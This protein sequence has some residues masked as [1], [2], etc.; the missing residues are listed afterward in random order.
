[1]RSYP[2]K[3]AMSFLFA[4]SQPRCRI[5]LWLVVVLALYN[6]VYQGCGAM[7]GVLMFMLWASACVVGMIVDGGG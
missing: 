3:R 1:M 4:R 6:R 5:P 2:Q 7:I